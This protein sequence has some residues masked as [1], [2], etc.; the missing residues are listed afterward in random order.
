[1]G[2]YIGFTLG[3]D[4]YV[5]W[6]SGTFA[7]VAG[8]LLIYAGCREEIDD[9]AEMDKVWMVVKNKTFYQFFEEYMIQG[10]L[11]NSDAGNSDNLGNSYDFL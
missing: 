3:P 7:L 2:L 6:V 4:I 5:G 8:A 9:D 1:M 11:A 10:C